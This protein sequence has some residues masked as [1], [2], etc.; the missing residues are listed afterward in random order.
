MPSDTDCG[1][2]REREREKK[3]KN[4]LRE[5]YLVT[6]C[7]RVRGP[8]DAPKNGAP[9]PPTNGPEGPLW[10][11]TQHLVQTP[12]LRGGGQ[13]SALD[14]GPLGLT[15]PKGGLWLRVRLVTSYKNRSAP[16]VAKKPQTPYTGKTRAPKRRNQCRQASEKKGLRRRMRP[17]PGNPKTP[18]RGNP[19]QETPIQIKTQS[20]QTFPGQFVQIAPLSPFLG[21]ENRQKILAQTVCANCFFWG[22][23][24]F[25]WVTFPWKNTRGQIKHPEKRRTR[26]THGRCGRERQRRGGQK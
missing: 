6:T 3:K 9:P 25:G 12:C 20:V 14:G 17:S 5:T 24:F 8:T 7:M 16:L 2:E 23:S 15:R 26:R 21:A 10:P 18:W 11:E 19:P 4:K 22:G 1:R 13:T